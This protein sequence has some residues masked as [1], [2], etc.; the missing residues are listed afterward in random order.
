MSKTIAG[1]IAAVLG[2]QNVKYNA[3][4]KECVEDIKQEVLKATQN[5]ID[6]EFIKYQNDLITA[7]NVVEVYDDSVLEMLKIKLKKETANKIIGEAR[8][9]FVKELQEAYKSI[10]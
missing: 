7:M 9:V 6:R 2:Q 10:V 5:V 4:R 1:A 8:V 3:L